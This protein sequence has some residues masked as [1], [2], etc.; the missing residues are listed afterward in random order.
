M[1]KLCDCGRPATVKLCGYYIC[2]RCKRHERERGV[3]SRRAG[4]RGTEPYHLYRV[5]LPKDLIAFPYD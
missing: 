2:A 4:T 5:A 3:R 1:N